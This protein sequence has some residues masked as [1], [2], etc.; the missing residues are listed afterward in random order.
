MRG[1]CVFLLLLLLLLEELKPFLSLKS[2]FFFRFEFFPL[3]GVVLLEE[4]LQV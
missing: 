4:E 1:G 3:E 2:L